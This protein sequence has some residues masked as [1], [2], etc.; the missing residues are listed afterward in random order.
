MSQNPS[1]VFKHSPYIPFDPNAF[2]YVE[3]EGRGGPVTP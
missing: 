3:S 1:A 2:T